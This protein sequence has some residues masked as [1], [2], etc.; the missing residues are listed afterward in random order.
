MYLD[1]VFTIYDTRYDTLHNN[2]TPRVF[3]S[4]HRNSVQ[5]TSLVGSMHAFVVSNI[6]NI[7][8]NTLLSMDFSRQ[9]VQKI[10]VHKD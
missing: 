5:L 1:T 2:K 6:L 7:M 4:G 8:L 3:A 10:A 9:F